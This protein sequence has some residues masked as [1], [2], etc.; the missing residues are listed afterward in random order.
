MAA[1]PTPTGQAV[2][3]ELRPAIDAF[4]EREAAAGSLRP[5]SLRHYRHD[6]ELFA[7]F[8]EFRARRPL[9]LAEITADHV[10]GFLADME[11]RGNS[12]SSRR[13]RLAALRRFFGA[14]KR[15]GQVEADPTELLEA[16]TKRPPR[17]VTLTRD[18]CLRLLEAAKTTHDPRRDHAVFLLFLT[19][20]CTLSELVGLTL[21]D[22]D[23]EAGTV[24]F[25]GR[26]E[27]RRTLFLS[28]GARDALEVYLS[29]RPKAPADRRALFLNRRGRPVTKGAI[30]YAFNRVLRKA[31]IDRPGV[32]IHTLRHTSL[33]FLWRAGVSLQ[34]MRYIAGHRSLAT[35]RQYGWAGP[36]PPK[37]QPW[38]WRHP[39]DD[40]AA[41]GAQNEEAAR[42]EVV[43]IEA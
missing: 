1:P 40:L 33:A 28:S 39:L 6:L 25:C 9:R 3:C 18:E 16:R 10:L 11:A 23:L 14:L 31:R 42:R 41:A 38:S 19:S 43:L 7:R 24:T 12:V 34:I 37:P 13:R 36:R 5:N 17:P 20:G 29:A 21:D 4:A 26:S 30:Y 15:A 35:T 2:S 27:R 22:V 32:T 8:V